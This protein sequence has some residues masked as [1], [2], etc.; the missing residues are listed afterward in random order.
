MSASK[1]I[2]KKRDRGSGKRGPN[3]AWA[4]GAL[5]LGGAVGILAKV[6]GVLIAPGM[7]GIAEQSAMTRTETLTSTLAYVLVAMLV[8][9]VSTGTFELARSPS[10]SALMHGFVVTISGL[11]I[12]LASPAV[13]DKLHPFAAFALAI[14]SAMVAFAVGILVARVPHTRALGVALIFLAICGL[15]QPTAWGAVTLASEHVSL[16]AFNVGRIAGT[17]AIVVQG[18]TTLLIAAWLAARSRVSRFF[19]N[20]AL[21]LAFAI[22]YLAARDH[23]PSSP[24]IAVLRASLLRVVS[25]PASSTVSTVAAFLLP[26][27]LL[28][29]VIALAQR[30]LPVAI[31][32]PFAFALLSL[33]GFDVPLQ[34]LAI[35]T[36][37]TWA[38]LATTDT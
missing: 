19:V 33:G 15:L 34:A 35:T 32:A 11:I 3:L 22:T 6:F 4:S 8:A 24:V 30:R 23:A 9:L 18:I 29:A 26:A 16:T 28:L 27:S 17:V 20:G 37:A 21:V 14:F 5:M 1:P 36:A 12:A 13:V 25:M 31:K 10:I 7:L 38:L 2:E